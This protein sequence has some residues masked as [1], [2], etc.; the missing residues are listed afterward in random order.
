[1]GNSLVIRA[2]GRLGG[3]LSGSSLMP[4]LC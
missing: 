3:P 1:L 2:S 4:T